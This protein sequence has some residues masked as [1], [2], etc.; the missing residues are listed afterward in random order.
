MARYMPMAGRSAQDITFENAVRNRERRLAEWIPGSDS[1][2]V[3]PDDSWDAFYGG[4]DR[5]REAANE[6]GNNFRLS[7]AGLGR[8]GDNSMGF[9]LA[10]QDFGNVGRNRAANAAIDDDLTKFRLSQAA[11]KAANAQAMA[12]EDAARNAAT[13]RTH[14]QYAFGDPSLSRDDVLARIPGHM[15]QGAEKFYADK[16][17]AKADL[18]LAERRQ[19][20]LEAEQAETERHNKAFERPGGG[21]PLTQT[22]EAG[23][24]GKLS[25]DWTKAN[26]TTAEM[27]RQ[28]QIM[29]AG[30]D[31]FEADPNGASQAVL[32]TFQKMLDPESVVRESEYARSS[33]GISMLHRMKGYAERLA[34][35]G[36]GVPKADL[37]EM[38]KTAQQFKENTKDA[39]AGARA[40][41]EAIADRYNLPHEMVFSDKGGAPAPAQAPAGGGTVKLQAPDGSTMDV[42]AAQA[43]H[44]LKLGAKRVGG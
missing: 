6:Q 44:Y 41:I 31:R 23:L 7:T 14:L 11:I 36:A 37:I 20:V 1:G 12:D 38:V 35:G 22:A 15:R 18:G 39:P 8:G 32:V 42:P 10:G 24:I 25:S 16:D 28:F 21:R 34:A 29:K 33:Q 43:E 17:K 9:S 5:A 30:L 3:L 2:G 4:V 26:Q 19:K 13:D 27:D 40:R